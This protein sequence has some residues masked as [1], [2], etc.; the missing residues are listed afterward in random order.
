MN[1]VTE[2][3]PS[4]G[5]ADAEARSAWSS[6]A[7]DNG[8]GDGSVETRFGDDATFFSDRTEGSAN[9]VREKLTKVGTAGLELGSQW[10]TSSQVLSE[11]DC[12]SML[13]H[14]YH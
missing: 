9:S 2:C 5:P 12:S 13:W 1:P 4:K 14:L 7:V 8:A 10:S 11:V 3:V 6:V